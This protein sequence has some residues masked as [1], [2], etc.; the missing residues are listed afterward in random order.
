M[1]VPSSRDPGVSG[2]DLPEA[3]LD[4]EWAGAVARNATILYVYGTDVMTAN[5]TPSI[6][7][8]LPWSP[9]ATDRASRKRSARI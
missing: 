7:T 6:R 8:W 1:L 3:D 5:N 9:R 2:N 4:L